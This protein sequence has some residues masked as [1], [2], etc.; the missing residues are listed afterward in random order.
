MKNVEPDQRWGVSAGVPPGVQV[1]LKNAWVPL[2][3]PNTDWQINSEGWISGDGR[4]YLIA[5]LT[6][7][8]PDE[9]YGIDTINTLSALLWTAMQLARRRAKP[10]QVGV[11]AATPDRWGGRPAWRAGSRRRRTSPCRQWPG[12]R[13]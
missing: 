7:G 3:P 6:T 11:R 1:A 8:N 2:T 5:V 4:D 9:Q 10:P 13:R 12:C